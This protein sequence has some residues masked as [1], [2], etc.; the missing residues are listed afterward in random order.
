MKAAARLS[1]GFLYVVSRPGTTGARDATA[2]GP[3][4]T[5]AARGARPPGG[6]TPLPDRGRVR[7]RLSR[8]GRD[9]PRAWRTASSWGRHSWPRREAPGKG[10]S[11]PSRSLAGAVS[12]APAGAHALN[13]FRGMGSEGSLLKLLKRANLPAGVAGTD[14]SGPRRETLPRGS[15]GARRPSPDTAIRGPLA[16]RDTLL[17]RSGAQLSADPRVH[18]EVRRAADRDLLRRLPE[19]ALAE[20]VDLAST[21]GRGTLVVLRPDPEP[22][23]VAGPARQP[24]RHGGRR[25]PG[26]RAGPRRRE[27]LAVIAA[28]P[29]WSLRQAVRSALLA[30]RGPSPS[31]RALPS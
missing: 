28:N 21:V 16:R 7:D 5:A 10:V 20:R 24:I 15:A 4:A 2:G 6:R 25:R 26:G 1:S 29:R 30:E 18:P 9:A 13:E 22:R 8:D 17:A 31:G 3:P 14:P 19:M 12:P 27:S 11:S 23:V